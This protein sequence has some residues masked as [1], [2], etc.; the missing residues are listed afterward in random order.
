MKNLWL[1]NE[2]RLAILRELL[3]CDATGGCDLRECLHIK[4]TLLSYHLAVLRQKGIVEESKQGRD[5]YYRI[6]QGKTAFVKKVI[7]VVE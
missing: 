2:K 5:K 3:G 1:F 6:A 7:A 4:K